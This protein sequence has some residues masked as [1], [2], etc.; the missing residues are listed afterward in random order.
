MRATD[1]IRLLAKYIA[2]YGDNEVEICLETELGKVYLDP[3]YIKRKGL[4]SIC[5]IL[6]D[7][8]VYTFKKIFKNLSGGE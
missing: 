3:M 5:E 6:I 8:D 2:D 7:F 4:D 1:M